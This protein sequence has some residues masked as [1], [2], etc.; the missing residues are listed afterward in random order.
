[1]KRICL[2]VVLFCMVSMYVCSDDRIDV[3]IDG[4]LVQLGQ[5]LDSG[6]PLVVSLDNILYQ[7]KKMGSSFSSFLSHKLGSALSRSS[8]FELFARQELEKIL[9]AIELS[10]SDLVDSSSAVRV[11]QLKGMQALITGNFFNGDSAV[12]VFLNLVQIETGTLLS[13]IEF[14]VPKNSI[15]ASVSIVPDN[16]NDALYVLNELSNMGEGQSDELG[17]KVWTTRGDGGTYRAGEEM[18]I[19]FFA[20]QDCYIK[21]YHIDVDKRMSLIF[22][23]QFYPDNHIRSGRI[24]KIPDSKY[25]FQFVLGAPFGLEF[26]KVIASTVQFAD[27]EE[28]FSDL[29]SASGQVIKRG[30]SVRQ[31][32]ELMSEAI[33]TQLRQKSEKRK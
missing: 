20:S 27:I 6:S 22:P 15:P 4:Q 9:E 28:S 13:K 21:L 32:E 3:L 33:L 18:I 5:T 19:Q 30:L 1:M 12:T 14:D 2:L 10:L 11:G 25:P 7:D 31:R 24:Y 8:K 23:N 29:G 26:I 17:V 16:Y